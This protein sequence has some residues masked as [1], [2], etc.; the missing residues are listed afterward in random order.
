MPFLRVLLPH[1]RGFQLIKGNTMVD[2]DGKKATANFVYHGKGELRLADHFP[3][4]PVFPGA[5]LL[6]GMAQTAIQTAQAERS[7]IS[8]D[9]L[10]VMAGIDNARFH[11]TVVPPAKIEYE[12]K[13][14]YIRR[15]IG[16]TECLA[17]VNDEVVAEATISFALVPKS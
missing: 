15:R 9:V 6:E 4:A 10:P 13:I 12:A 11:K 7:D 14:I 1:G 16:R 8:G 5:L 3:D 17:K 2:A